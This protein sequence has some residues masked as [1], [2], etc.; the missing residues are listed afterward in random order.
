MEKT[1]SAPKTLIALGAVGMS[2]AGGSGATRRV[3][4]S[5]R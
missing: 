4:G 2:G 5:G 3:R 1:V